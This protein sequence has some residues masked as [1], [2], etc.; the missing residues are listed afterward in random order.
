[1]SQKSTL[2]FPNIETIVIAPAGVMDQNQDLIMVQIG[3][4]HML[5]ITYTN[6]SKE[7]IK[8][9]K[10]LNLKVREKIAVLNLNLKIQRPLPLPR[11]NYILIIT[12]I[13]SLE[14]TPQRRTLG[15]TE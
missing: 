13:V 7:E 9:H 4:H 15:M 8:H 1:L 6:Q 5:T 14:K 11:L 2:K 12:T 10:I 3:I